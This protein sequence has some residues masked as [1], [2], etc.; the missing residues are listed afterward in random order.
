M[1]KDKIRTFIAF[2]FSHKNKESLFSTY[3]T[4]IPN[5][6]LKWVPQENLHC[7]LAF[8][9][10]ITEEQVKNIKEILSQLEIPSYPPNIKIN[11]LSAFPS[12]SRIRVLWLGPDKTP[13]WCKKI[14]KQLTTHLK[15]AKISFDQ[16][17]NFVFHITIART[18]NPLSPKEKEIIYKI[19][20]HLP[21]T[22]SL[23]S[24]TLFKSQLSSSHPI[25][26]PIF[27]RSLD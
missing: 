13:D 17:P 3:S 24:I 22:I 20:Q 18:K 4:I 7:T 8:L 23:K 11:R 10:L 16:K 1:G 12:L 5:I 26:S 27:Q 6:K 9:G 21:I 19:T 2:E 14:Y 25:Y 15:K